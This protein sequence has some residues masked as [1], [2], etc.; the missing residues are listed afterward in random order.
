MSFD[1]K[2][3]C[4]RWLGTLK[5]SRIWFKPNSGHS[6]AQRFLWLWSPREALVLGLLYV[7]APAQSYRV[8]LLNRSQLYSVGIGKHS[9]RFFDLTDMILSCS[10]EVDLVSSEEMESAN[11]PG[12]RRGPSFYISELTSIA[13]IVS[14]FFRSQ[15]MLQFQPV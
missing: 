10:T 6:N 3:T 15:L 1:Q 12:L 4:R 13:F 2:K 11:F 9:E 7:K 8:A 14:F 5:A